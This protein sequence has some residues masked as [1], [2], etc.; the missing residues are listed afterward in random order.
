MMRPTPPPR[1]RM[2]SIAALLLA[3]GCGLTGPLRQQ[4][5]VRATHVRPIPRALP[6][7][8]CFLRCDPLDREL[9]EE[10]W[11]FVDEGAVG[12]AITRRLNAN[13]IRA[14]IVTGHLPG[15]L[16]DRF[17][18]RTEDD[19]PIDSDDAAVSHRLLQ[20][21]PGRRAELVTGMP[22]DALVVL[23]RSGDGVH[24]TTYRSATS[25]FAVEVEPAADGRVRV[26]VIPEI[27]HGPLEKSWAGE[28]GAFR[29]QSGQRRDRL[30]AFGIDVT[31][32]R[33]AMLVIGTTGAE[34]TV[35]D[36]LLRDRARNMSR[37]VAIRPLAAGIDPVFASPAQAQGV[38][39][40]DPPLVVR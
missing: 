16:A 32:P 17:T 10:L 26:R 1:L 31:L 24:G 20:L 23:E 30:E 9:A 2:P 28:D 25:Q 39:D 3:T 37:L 33:D 4:A 14:G 40:D 7:E 19:P 8:V 18:A 5:D 27:R 29:L 12:D 36:G 21:L 6:V 15:H 34:G 22:L 35:G 11:T 38:D 13:G